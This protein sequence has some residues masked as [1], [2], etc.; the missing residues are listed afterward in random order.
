MAIKGVFTINGHD[1][2]PYIKHKTGLGWERDNTND[3]EA[4]RDTANTM[5][6]MVTSHQRKLTLKM[7]SMPF[8][9][10]Q[11]LEQDLQ[12]GDDGV[13]VKYPDLKDGICTRLFYNTSITAAI[14]Q[15]TEDGVV[16]DDINFTL[17]SIKEDTL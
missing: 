9:I 12:G 7:G 3:T 15:F 13:E 5:H 11:Q 6:P 14:E 1:Y 10:A 8:E 4:G 17:V 2:A 16:V